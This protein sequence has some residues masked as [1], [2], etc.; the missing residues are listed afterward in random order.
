[1]PLLGRLEGPANAED[2]STGQ[3]GL[4]GEKPEADTADLAS[5]RAEDRGVDLPDVGHRPAPELAGTVGGS[6]RIAVHNPGDLALGVDRRP[7]PS[8]RRAAEH[9]GENQ[10]SGEAQEPAHRNHLL[11]RRYCP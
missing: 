2:P 8:Q 9:P 5:A 11:L 6:R 1:M 3:L 4:S 7:T 10:D